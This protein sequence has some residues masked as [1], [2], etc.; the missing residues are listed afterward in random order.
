[1]TDEDLQSIFAYLRTVKLIH[2]RVDDSEIAN[3]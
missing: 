3:R 2:N 1:M